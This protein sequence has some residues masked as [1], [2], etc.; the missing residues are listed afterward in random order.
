MN[1]SDLSQRPRLLLVEDS[2]E[3]VELAR[4]ALGVEGY[5]DVQVAADGP[6]ALR[7]IREG[8]PGGDGEAWKPEWTLLDLR[9]PGMD[10]LEVLR[11]L[12]EDP[13]TAEARVIVLTS[14]EDPRDLQAC[15]GM[16][17]LGVLDKPLDGRALRGLLR[18]ALTG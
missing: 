3:D 16:G 15:R 7:V 8:L 1:P 2:A 5:T 13:A 4:W 12:R 10:G 9:M 18:A 17:V 6:S 14:T 11:R